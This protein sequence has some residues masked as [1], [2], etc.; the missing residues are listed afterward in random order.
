MKFETAR[1]LMVKRFSRDQIQTIHA[2]EKAAEARWKLRDDKKD[3]AAETPVLA[4]RAIFDR[5]NASYGPFW[6]KSKTEDERKYEIENFERAIFPI[7]R[8]KEQ[9]YHAGKGTELDYIHAVDLAVLTMTHQVDYGPV[10]IPQN[11]EE[12]ERYP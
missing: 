4:A 9:A 1:W 10:K 3:W 6:A 11:Y 12:R 7:W 2:C 8:P 5:F